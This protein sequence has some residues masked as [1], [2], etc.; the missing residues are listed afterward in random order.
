MYNVHPLIPL[1]GGFLPREPHPKILGV[2]FDTHLHF[3][4]HVEDL[5]KR[6]KKRLSLLKALTG[7]TWG[8]QKETIIATYKA[9]IDSLFSYA[10]PVWFPNTSA[11]NV[12]KLQVIQNAALRIATGSHMMASVDHLHME[13]EI[14][15]VGEHLDMLCA[16]SLA[17]FLQPL[18]ASF[19]TVTADSGPRRIKQTLQ[20]RF[21][22][23]VR[24]FVGE[25]GT[26]ADAATALRTIHCHAVRESINARGTNRVLGTPAPAISEEEEQLPRKTRR[27]LSQLRSGFS[28]SLEDYK[29]RIGLSASNL[30]PCCRQEEHSVQHVFECSAY[31]TDLQPLDLWLRPVLVAEFLRTLPFFDLPGE[32]RPPPEPP[33]PPVPLQTE[34][35]PG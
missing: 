2:T 7:T 32:E 29:H 26:V 24:S 19:P 14:M 6:A 33:P 15:K 16:Q 11:T 21:Q 5:V 3:H 17:T 23:R 20:S 28:A 34:S 35:T 22:A 13:A 30:C 10:A 12:S 4:K 27:T 31:P 25:D 8:Q 18:H 9:L 1:G